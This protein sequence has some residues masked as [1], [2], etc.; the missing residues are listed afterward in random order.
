M[1]HFFFN[2]FLKIYKKFF[3]SIFSSLTYNVNFNQKLRNFQF[4]LQKSKEI[5]AVN[6]SFEQIFFNNTRLLSIGTRPSNNMHN[7]HVHNA[8]RPR[9]KAR[10]RTARSVRQ[11]Q[12]NPSCFLVNIPFHSHTNIYHM[13]NENFDCM[14]SFHYISC[15]SSMLNN[16]TFS[17]QTT[18]K[19]S[20]AL[21]IRFTTYFFS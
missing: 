2:F 4:Q 14:C 16:S 7:L 19:Y 13:S 12:P 17:I 3:S 1:P 5:F 21:T 9:P 8:N 6:I 18:R 15:L 10:Y 20:I 11:A